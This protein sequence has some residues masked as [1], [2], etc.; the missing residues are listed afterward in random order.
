[1]I[2]WGTHGKRVALQGQMGERRKA[3]LIQMENTKGDSTCATIV[4]PTMSR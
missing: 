3:L 1:M 4:L 2:V